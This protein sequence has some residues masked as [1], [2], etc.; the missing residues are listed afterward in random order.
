MTNAGLG[1]GNSTEP[2]RVSRRHL[3]RLELTFGQN[4]RAEL[5][6]RSSERRHA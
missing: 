4:F 5:R 6:H 1:R 3:G 2:A